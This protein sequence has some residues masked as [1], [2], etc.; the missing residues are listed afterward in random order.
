M[1]EETCRYSQAWSIYTEFIRENSADALQEHRQKTGAKYVSADSLQVSPENLKEPQPNH[2]ALLAD[3][4]GFSEGVVRGSDSLPDFYG[5]ALVG[6]YQHPGL[7]VFVLSDSCLVV[8]DSRQATSLLS[9]AREFASSLQQDGILH[10]IVLGAGTFTERKPDFTLSADNFLGT[11]VVGT[12]IV[13]AANLAKKGAFGCRILLTDAAFDEL[14]SPAQSEVVHLTNGEHEYM[15]DRP[16][17][18]DLLDSIHYALCLS[19]H[20]RETR[21]HLHFLW[22]LA[23]RSARMGP[24]LTVTALRLVRKA[25]LNRPGFSGGFTA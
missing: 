14:D 7:R 24:N 12:A 22:S 10:Q 5:A 9:F 2:L 25:E 6:A 15:P 17:Q 23:S 13:D 20:A 19:D 16:P 18:F 8:C 21:V 1:A 11:Q 3:I 4:L